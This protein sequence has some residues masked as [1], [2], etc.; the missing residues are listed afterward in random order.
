MI[1]NLGKI[2]CYEKENKKKRKKK[3]QNIKKINS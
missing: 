3:R 1:E 2:I